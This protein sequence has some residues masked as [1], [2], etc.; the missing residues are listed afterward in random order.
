MEHRLGKHRQRATRL[1]IHRFSIRG[2]RLIK[3][4]TKEILVRIQY[5]TFTHERKQPMELP[6]IKSTDTA[7]EIRAKMDVREKQ[8][9]SWM[10]GARALAKVLETQAPLVAYTASADSG[11]S[12]AESEPAGP[13]TDAAGNDSE[14]SGV[15]WDER[16]AALNALTTVAAIERFRRSLPEGRSAADREMNNKVFG[17]RIEALPEIDWNDHQSQLNR[18]GETTKVPTYCRRASKDWSSR[19]CDRLGVMGRERIA[20]IEAESGSGDGETGVD[21]GI[22]QVA[23]DQLKTEKSVNR[24]REQTLPTL[25]SGDSRK[26][27]AMCNRKI[28]EI[29]A[30]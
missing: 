17:E 28:D 12:V 26:F 29:K 6:T 16:R 19:D 23:V 21:W 10:A 30:G 1:A 9:R 3:T 14:V 5:P 13:G 11:D 27:N 20:E 25:N 15:D 8:H 2:V 7:D 4:P 22:E 24:H 18:I